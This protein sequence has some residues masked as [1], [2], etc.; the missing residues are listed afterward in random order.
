[1]AGPSFLRHLYVLESAGLIRTE[2]TAGSHGAARAGR[3]SI[4]GAMGR[5]H[6]SEWERRFDGLVEFLKQGDNC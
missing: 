6:R 1:M 4:G 3:V 2:K 5:R